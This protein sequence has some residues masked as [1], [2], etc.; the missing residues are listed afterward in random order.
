MRDSVV[1]LNTLAVGSDSAERANSQP[2]T[3]A[4]EDVMTSLKLSA[5]RLGAPPED[6]HGEGALKELF[7]KGGYSGHAGNLAHLD[8]DRLAMPP[9]G[10]TPVPLEVLEEKADRRL[11]EGLLNATLPE[12][13]AA[14]K[15]TKSGVRRVYSCDNLRCPRTY[16]KLVKRLHAAELVKFTAECECRVG[17]FAVKKKNDEQRLVLDCRYSSCHFEDPPKVHLASGQSFASIEVEPGQNV[18]LGNVDIKVAFYAMQLPAE[19]MKYFGLPYDVRAGDVG[20]T[21]RWS[22]SAANYAPI[23]PDTR[24]VPVFAAIPMG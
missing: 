13:V 3:A 12:K 20:V 9:E 16:L 14:E 17:M 23:D 10:F 4:Q 7:A 2:L 19:L 24:I 22:E 18:W 15:K 1:A 21:H 6:M 8:I 5:Q 11:V